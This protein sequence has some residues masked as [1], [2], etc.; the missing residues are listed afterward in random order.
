MDWSV[1]WIRFLWI[2][3]LMGIMLSINAQSQDSV[4]IHKTDRTWWNEETKGVEYFYERPEMREVKHSTSSPK[5]D[6]GSVE[7][8]KYFVLILIAGVL[9]FVLY[10]LYGQSMFEFTSSRKAKQLLNITEEE[11]DERF[12]E[13]DLVKMLKIAES[14]KN[15]KMAL[16]LRFLQVLKALVDSE[17]IQWHPDLT[18]RQISYKLQLGEQRT[19][20]NELVRIYEF[21]WY[22]NAEVDAPYYSRV[23][24]KFT[25]YRKG[26]IT[27]V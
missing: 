1:R 10:R 4:R 21:A 25:L 22:S 12:L 16:R 27:N 5:F 23:K 18:N 17:S 7:F 15:W 11:L 9:V 14:R 3:G 20:F 6:W 2:F 13:L 8:L 26:F 24:E 19:Q